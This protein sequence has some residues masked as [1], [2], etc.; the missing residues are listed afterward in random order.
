MI[1]SNR[2]EPI[3]FKKEVEKEFFEEEDYKHSDMDPN[4]VKENQKDI[5]LNPGI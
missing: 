4:E 1:K 3:H 2:K 5:E